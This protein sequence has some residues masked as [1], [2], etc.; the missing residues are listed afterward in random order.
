MRGYLRTRKQKGAAVIAALQER[1]MR[2]LQMHE[3]FEGGQMFAFQDEKLHECRLSR[4]LCNRPVR[5]TLYEPVGYMSSRVRWTRF[6]GDTIWAR[7]FLP[8]CACLADRDCR[9]S[10]QRTWVDPVR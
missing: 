3:L 5:H 2:E 9:A 6:G 10:L 4:F 8:R 1:M 7:I